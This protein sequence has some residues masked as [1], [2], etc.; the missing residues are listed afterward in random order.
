VAGRGRHAA[1]KSLPLAQAVRIAAKI[2]REVFF[3]GKRGGPAT[4]A[5]CYLQ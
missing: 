5:R 3:Q 4:F 2:E 1:G